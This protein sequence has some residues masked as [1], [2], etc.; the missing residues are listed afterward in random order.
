MIFETDF[1][2]PGNSALAQWAFDPSSAHRYAPG[3]IGLR[4][5]VRAVHFTCARD[6]VADAVL[7]EDRGGEHARSAS[8]LETG[9]RFEVQGE[10]RR[11]FVRVGRGGRMHPVRRDGD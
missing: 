9:R 6:G 4:V 11:R 2:V 5:A 10:D 7:T 1:D 8:V 3:C